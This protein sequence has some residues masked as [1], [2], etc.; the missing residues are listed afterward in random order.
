MWFRS[1]TVGCHDRAAPAR[2]AQR[3][4]VPSP[5]RG[6][7]HVYGIPTDLSTAGVSAGL[8]AGLTPVLAALPLAFV[9]AVLTASPIARRL[10]TGRATAFLLVLGFAGVLGIT[11]IPQPASQRLP[12]DLGCLVPALA[13]PAQGRLAINDE[14][15]NVAL[16]VPLGIAVGLLVGHPRFPVLF[17]A[18]AALPWA[19][20]A[21][22][23]AMPA[24]GRSCQSGDLTANLL[25]LLVGVAIGLVIGLGRRL[26]DGDRPPV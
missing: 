9:L 26:L 24:L 6:V 12:A 8:A 19:I 18:A 25:G 2:R 11:L 13:L 4:P 17:V 10:G 20:E 14:T 21:I 3:A 16:F 23:L 15:L 5:A 7:Q 1:G 22:Q